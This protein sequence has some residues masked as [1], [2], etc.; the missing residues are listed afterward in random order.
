V[1]KPSPTVAAVAVAVLSWTLSV[2]MHHP[3]IQGNIYSDVT[4]FW[5]REESLQRAKIPCIQYFFEYPPTACFIVYTARILGGASLD[6]YYLAFSLLSLPAYLAIAWGLKRLAG[7]I[8]MLF[9]LSPSLIVYGIYNFDHFFTALIVSSLRMLLTKRHRISFFLL[10]FAFSVKLFS[11]LLLPIYMISLRKNRRN[12]VEGI[13]YFTAGALTT[14][15]PTILLNPSWL[16]EF[17]GFHLTWGMEN[18]WII[19]FTVDPF[20]QSGKILG[21][22]TAAMLLLRAY[23]VNASLAEKGFLVFSGWLLGSPVFTPQMVIWLLP[24]ITSIRN[25]WYIIPLFE[26]ANVMII[27]TWFTTDTPTYPWT[28]PQTMALLRSAALMGMWITIYRGLLPL[29]N[30]FIGDWK[31]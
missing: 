3:S 9:V 16:F 8:G 20:S 13:I 19:W 11:I 4:S 2:V 23:T 17:I 5:W 12:Y 31:R 6:G 21:Y 1:K 28:L 30:S 18:S 27:F 24:F 14:L 29:K 7:S 26:I 25:T 22:L 10:G 15:L